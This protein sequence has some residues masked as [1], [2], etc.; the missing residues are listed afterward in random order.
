MELL[1][2][3]Y[4][5]TVARLEH[6]TRAADELGIAQPLSARPLLAWR[7]SWACLYLIVW[8]ETFT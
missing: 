4:F 1:Q 8:D 2:L 3:K 5:L 6:M 7:K